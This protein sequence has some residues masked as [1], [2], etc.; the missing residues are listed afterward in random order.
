MAG[1]WFDMKSTDSRP[2]KGPPITVPTLD[3][4]SV[5]ISMENDSAVT[6]TKPPGKFTPLTNR[7]IEK[8]VLRLSMTLLLCADMGIEHSQ[9][10]VQ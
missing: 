2:R 6:E 1:V 5:L 3:L 4:R 10:H 9:H 8:T 7:K